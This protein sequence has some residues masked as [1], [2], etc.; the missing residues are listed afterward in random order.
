MLSTTTRRSIH[1]ATCD[2]TP[3]NHSK[4]A[5]GAIQALPRPS[6]SNVGCHATVE[7]SLRGVI[8]PWRIS[9]PVDIN[10]HLQTPGVLCVSL[11]QESAVGAV[12]AGG[13]PLF[14]GFGV[15]VDTQVAAVGPHSVR[16]AGLELRLDTCGGASWATAD[17]VPPSVHSTLPRKSL[18]VSSPPWNF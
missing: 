1:P 14:A 13:V 9:D 10:V 15:R 6:L 11:A 17:H 5:W 3:N 8:L 12:R 18:M 16:V 4:G 7:L 2:A